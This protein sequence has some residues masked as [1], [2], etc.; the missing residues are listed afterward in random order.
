MNIVATVPT[1]AQINGDFSQAM[2]YDQNGNP[3]QNQIFDPFLIDPVA[4]ARPAYANNTIPTGEI[5]PV[6]QAILKL[7]PQPNTAGDAVSGA[8]N[9]RKVILST[10]TAEQFDVKIDQHFSDKSTLSGRYSMVFANGSTPTV[11]GDGEFN[12]GLAYT[13]RVFNEAPLAKRISMSSPG[14]SAS[15]RCRFMMSTS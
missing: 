13:E 6:G 14:I 1:A 2:T 7:Y 5:D 8:N 9:F 4:Y 10:S 3:V 15:A 12:D 11:F